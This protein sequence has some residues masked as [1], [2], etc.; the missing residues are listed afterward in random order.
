MA[1]AGLRHVFQAM[2]AAICSCTYLIKLPMAEVEVPKKQQDGL[3]TVQT[4]PRYL[5]WSPKTLRLENCSK[6][7][8]C[9][10]D[11]TKRSAYAIV[12]LWFIW[13]SL[14]FELKQ[15]PFSHQKWA[16]RAQESKIIKLKCQFTQPVTGGKNPCKPMK[17]CMLRQPLD[18]LLCRLLHACLESIVLSSSTKKPPWHLDRPFVGQ[19][20][21]LQFS[22][23]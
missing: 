18:S 13:L 14:P 6:A 9:I 10:S 11:V 4:Q 7:E 3:A 17:M 16:V 8:M 21:I 15:E 1:A 22:T 23:H 20:S 12:H 5:R 19:W 2:H